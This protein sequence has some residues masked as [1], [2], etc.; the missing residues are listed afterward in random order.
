MLIKRRKDAYTLE[1]SFF[2]FISYIKQLSNKQKFDEDYFLLG[3]KEK[4]PPPPVAHGD[5]YMPAYLNTLQLTVGFS[6]AQPP[7]ILLFTFLT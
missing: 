7:I 4:H 1:Y 6:N 5:I 3:I 2:S